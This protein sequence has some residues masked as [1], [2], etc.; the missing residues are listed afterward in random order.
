MTAAAGALRSVFV[1]G[2][3][4]GV[5][6]LALPA[7]RAAGHRVSGLHRSE[8]QAGVL[9]EAGARPV[10]G[11]LVNDST[12]ELAGKLAGHDAVVFSAGAG[13]SGSVKDIDEG[14]AV[15]AVDAALQAGVPR[16]V[17]VSVFM[18][19][20]RGAQS[21]GEAFE[22]YMAAKRS[23][24]VHLSASDLDFLIVRP[25]TLTDDAGTGLV[26]AG[27]AIEY[28]A[29]PRADVAA[30]VAEALSVPDLSRQAFEITTGRT[31]VQEAVAAL[32]R[33]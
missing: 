7:L 25:G 22:Q 16:F 18:D 33:R 11:D 9:T 27:V 29:I 19:A 32:R 23:A 20:W 3:T 1:I 8:D 17:L 26:T 15:K 12:E 14:G 21:P 30:F 31:P 28:G 10:R 4:G 2:A 24:D 6:R 13:G 5:G